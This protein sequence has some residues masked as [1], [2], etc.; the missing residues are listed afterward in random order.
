MVCA[1]ADADND[2]MAALGNAQTPFS[3]VAKVNAESCLAGSKCLIVHNAS[4]E[5][6]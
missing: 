2:V 5:T 4:Q 3:F 6:P 1:L